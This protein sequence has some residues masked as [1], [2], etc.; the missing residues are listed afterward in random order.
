MKNIPKIVCFAFFCPIVLNYSEGND[1][2][3]VK[4]IGV[5]EVENVEKSEE[6]GEVEALGE[7]KDQKFRKIEPAEFQVESANM[8]YLPR[9]FSIVIKVT[10]EEKSNFETWINSRVGKKIAFISDLRFV[11]VASIRER[12]TAG[13]IHLSGP[14][15]LDGASE[16]LASING[17]GNVRN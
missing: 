17:K 12:I 11:Y 1:K 15:T 5:C 9:G 10:D 4:K 6:P 14:F 3:E 16:I 8:L 7:Y 2:T 13:T